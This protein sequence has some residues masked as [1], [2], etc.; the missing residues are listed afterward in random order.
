VFGEQSV[1]R[2]LALE[3][4]GAAGKVNE[5]VIVRAHDRS[6]PLKLKMF[7][8]GNRTQKSFS[9]EEGKEAA[10]D[11]AAPKVGVGYLNGEKIL[12]QIHMLEVFVMWIRIRFR[13]WD[14]V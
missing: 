9:L 7:F 5:C 8:S 14:F 12:V 6:L 2:R 3:H 4:A 11:W 1:C 13:I 10:Q